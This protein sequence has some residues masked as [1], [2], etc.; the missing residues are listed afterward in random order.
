LIEVIG[1]LHEFLKGRKTEFRVYL[2]ITT[3]PMKVYYYNNI[4]VRKCS[5]K[6][7]TTGVSAMSHICSTTSES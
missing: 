3:D 4:L 1:F 5:A 7:N 2:M 6:F